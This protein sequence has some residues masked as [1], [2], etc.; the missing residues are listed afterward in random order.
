MDDPLLAV[1]AE[2]ARAGARLVERG[3]VLGSSGNLSVRVGDQVVTTPSGVHLDRL[4]AADLPVLSL[5]GDQ[6]S[7]TLLPTSEVSLH[8]ALIRE[9]GAGAV[10]HTHAPIATA[11]ACTLDE[12][13]LVHYEMLLLGGA[14][15]VAPFAPFGTP[16]LAAGALEAL[17]GRS[18]ALLANHGT[19]ATGVDLAAALRATE[20]LEW[21]A[22]VF[23]RA[24]AMG[25][26][27]TL[28]AEQA[29]ATVASAMRLGYGTPRAAPTPPE[30]PPS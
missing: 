3:L 25:T 19:V 28:T 15:R 22:T 26:P 17:E 13:P 1:R 23:W 6:L 21:S 4:D 27:R 20:L 30:R 14:I 8:L 29:A 24:S 10:V 7:G 12:L 11:L 5:G 18:A 9:A 2:I 16:E